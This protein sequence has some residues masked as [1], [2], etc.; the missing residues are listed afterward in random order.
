MSLS[1]K[2]T[3]FP[4]LLRYLKFAIATKAKQSVFDYQ[5]FPFKVFK[6]NGVASLDYNLNSSIGGISISQ[7][8]LKQ[9]LDE[10]VRNTDTLSF[11]VLKDGKVAYEYFADGINGRTPL[12]CYSITKSVFAS[13]LSLLENNGVISFSDVL[14]KYHRYL[15]DFLANRTFQSLMN[16]ES[17]IRYTHGK[18]PFT[19]MVRFWLSPDIRRDLKTIKPCRDGNGYF[20]YNDI[21]LHLLSRMIDSR[22][23]DLSVDI[24]HNFWQQLKPTSN[25][26]FCMDSLEERHLKMDGGMAIAPHDL[27][28]FG[29]LYANDGTIHGNQVLN[30]EWC[31][32]LKN[33]EGVRTDLEYWDLYRKMKHDWYP[34]L[35]QERT[36]YKNFWWGIKQDEGAN[37]I[38]AMGILGQFVYVSTRNNVVIVRQGNSWGVKGWWPYIFEELASKV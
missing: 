21:H 22:I 13:Y 25:T 37:D 3:D 32:N 26:L 16:M 15:P 35:K 36:Y 9:N 31:S 1:S 34:I 28:K 20:Y 17:G 6:G 10:L 5:Y 18:S 11:L 2:G 19:D 27:A 8:N 24:N 33:S 12:L 38:Y 23:S 4:L 7:N 14:S 29:L 30:K